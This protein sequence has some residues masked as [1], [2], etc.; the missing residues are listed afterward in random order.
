MH[1]YYHMDKLVIK[2]IKSGLK[3]KKCESCLLTTWLGDEI[4]LERHHVD[5]NKK[6]NELS[7][8]KLLC[9]NCHTFTPNY[10][11][12]GKKKIFAKFISDKKLIKL[13][14]SS[15]TRLEVILKCKV[16]G[17]GTSYPRMDKIMREKNIQLLPSKFHSQEWKD[18]QNKR[19]E[20]MRIKYNKSVADL[21][22]KKIEWPEKDSLIKLITE[23]SVRSVGKELGVSDN[24]VRKHLKRLDV[25]VRDYS[26]WSHSHGEK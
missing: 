9:P 10:R 6:N 8:L 26:K 18:C 22:R 5:G 7:N 19:I 3:E 25:N 2:L 13:I 23:K 4:P 16:L 15:H 12:R 1:M 17:G 14:K 21:F 20:T 11:G 24:A